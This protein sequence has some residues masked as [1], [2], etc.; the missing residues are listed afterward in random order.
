MS[1][2]FFSALGLPS[3]SDLW[4]ANQAR[5]NAT[6]AYN[7]MR[8][9]E[10]WVGSNAMQWRVE[11]LKK[12]GLNPLLATSS[13]P[14]VPAS[15]PMASAPPSSNWNPAQ[16]AAQVENLL[17]NAELARSQASK[18]RSETLPVPIVFQKDS[19]GN[20]IRDK[21]GNLIPDWSRSGGGAT[22]VNSA[23]E[24]QK[25][26]QNLDAAFG[27]MMEQTRKAKADA[28]L[29]EIE[30]SIRGMDRDMQEQLFATTKAAAI[31]DYRA[32]HASASVAEAESAVMGGPLG[33][34]FKFLGAVK[35]VV[36]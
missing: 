26:Q 20:E 33:S 3:P 19:S 16:S 13:S 4:A 27:L 17:A 18:N 21:D 9:N 34:V 23:L 6:T 28:D 8:E 12:A 31:A 35:S 36:K 32:K 24:S 5:D 11:D 7:R 1:D 22:A 25:R 30:T 2:N 29:S 14:S 15:A 10:Q